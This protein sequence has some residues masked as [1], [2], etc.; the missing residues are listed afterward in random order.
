MNGHL[1]VPIKLY[2]Q[3][4]A[5]V[6]CQ[7]PDNSIV[8]LNSTIFTGKKFLNSLTGINNLFFLFFSL[9]S[10]FFLEGESIGKKKAEVI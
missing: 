2:S 8:L 5:A 6:V 3:K 7:P 10:I 1:S 9:K 4:Q